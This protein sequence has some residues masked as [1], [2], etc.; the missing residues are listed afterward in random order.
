MIISSWNIR[1]L[2]MAPKQKE[3]A[4][5]FRSHSL[6]ILV[7]LETHVKYHKAARILIISVQMLLG[8]VTTIIVM[9]VEFG[10]FGIRKRCILR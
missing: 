4:S 7:V 8:G 10:S 5:F 6:A 3:V 9:M 2:N 1:G